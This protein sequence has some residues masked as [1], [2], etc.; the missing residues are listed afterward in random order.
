MR[1]PQYHLSPRGGR[2]ILLVSTK[3]IHSQKN[4]T[5]TVEAPRVGSKVFLQQLE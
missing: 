2:V 1:I 5:D 3:K 4:R